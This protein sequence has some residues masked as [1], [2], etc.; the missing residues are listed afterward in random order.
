MKKVLITG[1]A[2]FIGY[3]LAKN[4]AEKDYEIHIV[5][6]LQR[7]TKDK[8]FDEL[9]SKNNIS[10]FNIDLLSNNNLDLLSEEYYFIFHLAAIVGVKNVINSPYE[11]LNKNYLLLK[12]TLDIAFRQKKLNRFIFA[13]TSEVYAGTLKDF[14]MEFPTPETTPLSVGTRFTGRNTYML[15]KIYGESIC[16]HSGLPYTIMR[17]HNFYGPRMGFSHVIPELLRKSHQSVDGKILV[18]NPHHERSFCFIDDA[19]D[20]IINLIV[21]SASENETFNIG[22]ENDEISM[23]NLAKKIVGIVDPNLKINLE[24][25]YNDSPVRRCPNMKKAKEVISISNY[26][27]LDEGISRCNDWY[28]D[29]EISSRGITSK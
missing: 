22:N 28:F 3:Y 27:S 15:S 19:V 14:S 26:I 13:S 18:N 10:F 24:D 11:V 16:T 17:P 1:G 5:D 9:I 21:N 20:I 12:N 25:D 4:F 7:G 2:G 6:N 29:N 23:L 8:W